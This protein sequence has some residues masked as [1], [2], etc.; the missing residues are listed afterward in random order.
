[1]SSLERRPVIL[2]LQNFRIL[3]SFSWSL[4][5]ELLMYMN[6]IIKLQHHHHETLSSLPPSTLI[7]FWVNEP[8]PLNSIQFNSIQF[9]SIQFNSASACTRVDRPSYHKYEMKKIGQRISVSFKNVSFTRL[10]YYIILNTTLISQWNSN[11]KPAA[12]VNFLVKRRKM[13]SRLT[14]APQGR[15]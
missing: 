3:H 13:K 12:T 8:A 11:H 6:N 7:G 2:P 14:T 5:Y 9:N 10:C 1:M 15:V 4:Y